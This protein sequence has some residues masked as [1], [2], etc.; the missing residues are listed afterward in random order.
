M[1]NTALFAAE[2]ANMIN[3]LPGQIKAGGAQFACA[4]DSLGQNDAFE[5]VATSR[6]GNI[7]ATCLLSNFPVPPQA[8]DRVLI[9]QVGSTEWNPFFIDSVSRHSDGIGVAL[10]LRADQNGGP[11]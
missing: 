8:E 7:V 11:I 3:D 10:T 5:D 4:L 9:Q 2:L 1:L 6:M